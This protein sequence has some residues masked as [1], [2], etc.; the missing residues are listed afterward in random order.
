MQKY[1]DLFCKNDSGELEC[2]CGAWVPPGWHEI[3]DDLCGAITQ[4]TK[5]T[6]RTN[7]EITSNMYYFWNACTSFVDWCYKRFLKMFPKCNKW[8]YNKPVFSFIEKFRQRSCKC[9]KYNKVYPPAVKIDQIKEKFGGLRFYY[10]GGDDCVKGMVFMAEHLC[11]KTCDATGEAGV[12]CCRHH[13][14][15]TLSPKLLDHEM[16]KGYTIVK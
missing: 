2:P 16:Y 9:V 13:W 4:Y 10:S 15:K 8:E 11:S 7:M 3:V 5:C 14:F 1:P 12:L 6:Y